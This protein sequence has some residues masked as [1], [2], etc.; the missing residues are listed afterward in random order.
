MKFQLIFLFI[1]ASIIAGAQDIIP[2][3]NEYKPTGGFFQISD[4]VSLSFS[5]KSFPDLVPVFTTSV[6]KYTHLDVIQKKNNGTIRLVRNPQITEKE[7]YRMKIEPQRITV[8][9]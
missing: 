7:A 4:A 9:A 3:P 1:I 6:K 5:D 2:R 8:E